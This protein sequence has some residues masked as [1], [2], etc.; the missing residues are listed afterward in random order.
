MF[1]I[2]SSEI[3]KLI[4]TNINTHK[5]SLPLDDFGLPIHALWITLIAKILNTVNRE[6]F[7]VV[8][9]SLFSR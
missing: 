2:Y 4:K 8:L 6:I 3:I 7:T 1:E 9:F 5:T